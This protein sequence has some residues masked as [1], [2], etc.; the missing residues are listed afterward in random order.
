MVLSVALKEPEYSNG[1]RAGRGWGQRIGDCF[2]GQLPP[3]RLG[4]VPG[5]LQLSD[6]PALFTLL[7]L[8]LSCPDGP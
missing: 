7:S 3:P 1:P 8:P 2:P 4:S 6:S 5:T